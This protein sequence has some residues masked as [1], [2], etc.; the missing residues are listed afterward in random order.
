[1]PSY[2]LTQ[3]SESHRCKTE[4]PKVKPALLDHNAT[5]EPALQAHA[6]P[7][8]LKVKPKVKHALLDHNAP[9]EHAPQAH[10]PLHELLEN[11]T[12]QPLKIT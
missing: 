8:L 2:Q 3:L 12:F 6:P 11:D 9:Q 5:Q 10:A 7:L 1:M 4:E